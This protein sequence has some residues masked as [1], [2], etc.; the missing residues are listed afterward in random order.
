[1]MND[2]K[3]INR[4]A[5]IFLTVLALTA[6][7]PVNPF[8]LDATYA[9]PF[10]RQITPATTPSPQTQESRTSQPAA[11]AET[12]TSQP[13]TPAATDRPTVDPNLLSGL[14]I[15]LIQPWSG[16]AGQDLQGLVEEYNRTNELGIQVEISSPGTIEA[17]NELMKESL[18]AGTPPDV[19]LAY[20]FQALEWDA[21]H[22]FVDLTPYVEDPTW[23]LNAE[24][25][26]DF[27]PALWEAGMAGDRRLAVPAA[28]SGQV[29][30]YNQ[31]W[32]EELG[33]TAPPA[34]PAELER[35]VCAA[36]QANRQDQSTD[37]DGT[38]GLI[39][40]TNYSPML[41]WL[42]AFGAQVYDPARATGKSSPYHFSAPEVA[43]A[44][45]FLRGLYDK[46][47]AWLPDEPYP[48]EDFSSRRGLLAANSLANLA[49]Q[50]SVNGRAGRADRWT[51]IPFP[52]PDG[53]PA[54]S[55]YGP[56]LEIFST[57]PEQQLA[58]WNFVRWLLSPQNQARLAGATNSFPA[59]TSAFDLLSGELADLPQ[60]TAARQALEYARPEPTTSSWKTV[61]WALGDAATQLFRSYFS[62][63]KVPELVKLLNQTAADLHTNPPQD[64]E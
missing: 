18:A 12:A 62:I 38:G 60:W 27:N 23:G 59:R 40:S 21:A 19:A 37:N 61:R 55:T 14:T 30:Y 43:Q 8:Y 36:A 52:S 35:Q 24:E 46:G 53:E 28:G 2:R 22:P 47:C 51:V 5:L 9:A 54:I 56:G 4:I 50:T 42:E 15:R 63:D 20:L 41:A 13:A 3:I 7:V 44:F 64:G 25:R 39:L 49:Y 1:M 57:T 31:T 11:A 33:F 10:A 6:C 34:T 48:E 16:Q 45:T 29:L 58:A 26:A 32:A 17:M